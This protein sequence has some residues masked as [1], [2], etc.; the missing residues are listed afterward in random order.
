MQTKVKNRHILKSKDVKELIDKIRENYNNSFF[1]EKSNVETGDMEEYKIIL[2]ENEPVFVVHEN[3]MVFTLKGLDRFK[4]QEKFVTVD[5][6]AVRFITSGA[7]VMA[8][9][10][11]DADRNIKENQQVWICDE[12]HKK[13]LA[14]GFALMNGE[15]MVKEE[16]GKAVKVV[17]YVGDRLWN[18]ISKSL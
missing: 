9:G 3:K 5:M 4:P 6:G 16:K 7:D 17:H 1:D 12:K 13:P 8:P 15:Q 10:I 14:V 2:I 18:L 11:V